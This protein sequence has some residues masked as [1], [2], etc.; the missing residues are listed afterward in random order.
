M[1][2]SALEV[3]KRFVQRVQESHEKI[4][5]YFKFKRLKWMP[6]NVKKVASHE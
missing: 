3:K 1:S 5:D 6:S 2:N 4:R